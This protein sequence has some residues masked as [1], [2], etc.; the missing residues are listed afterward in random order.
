MLQVKRAHSHLIPQY[1][2]YIKEEASRLKL[3][4]R[5]LQVLTFSAEAWMLVGIAYR[6]GSV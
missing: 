1:M 5:E 3:E 2:A 6:S 4:N